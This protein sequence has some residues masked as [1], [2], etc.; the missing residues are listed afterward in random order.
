[1]CID[2][3]IKFC[4]THTCRALDKNISFGLL[5]DIGIAKEVLCLLPASAD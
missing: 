1:M 5:T 2:V 3:L 4:E